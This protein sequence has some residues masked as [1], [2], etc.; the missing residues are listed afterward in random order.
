MAT[1][2]MLLA[3]SASNKYLL[4]PEISKVYCHGDLLDI[5]SV[6]IKLY[7]QMTLKQQY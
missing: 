4:G 3:G 7:F 1:Y 6:M 5:P 2:S